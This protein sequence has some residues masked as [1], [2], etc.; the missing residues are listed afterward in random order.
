MSKN[1]YFIREKKARKTKNSTVIK[2]PFCAILF[3]RG[4]P[5]QL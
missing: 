1:D 4:R 3:E 5:M 2:L